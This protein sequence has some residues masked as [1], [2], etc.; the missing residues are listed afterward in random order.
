MY[1]IQKKRSGNL[2][3][4]TERP[5]EGKYYETDSIPGGEGKLC[6]SEEKG[7]YRVKFPAPATEQAKPKTTEERI[8]ELENALC[9]L[10]AAN[11]EAHATYETA[12]C[13]L[14]ETLNGG[15]V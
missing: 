6:F 11:E 12:L 14:D 9:D 8:A 13:D 5:T 1:Y 3:I 10:D 2:K 15:T 4:G 7:L